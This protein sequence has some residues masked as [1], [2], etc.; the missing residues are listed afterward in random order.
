MGPIPPQRQTGNRPG[1]VPG[2][3]G[4]VIHRPST[5]PTE[6]VSWRRGVEEYH[7]SIPVIVKIIITG[8]W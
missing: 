7:Q 3:V 8:I 1:E 6:N 4:G 2:R 5:P